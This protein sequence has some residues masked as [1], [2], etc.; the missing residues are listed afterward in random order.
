MGRKEKVCLDCYE[1]LWHEDKP[2]T[3]QDTK[4]NVLLTFDNS[5]DEG[6]NN[7]VPKIWRNIN[8]DDDEKGK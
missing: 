8:N 4:G 6:T 5:I 2:R 1:V 7:L 3:W